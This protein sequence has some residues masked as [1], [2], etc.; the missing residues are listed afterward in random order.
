MRIR[1]LFGILCVAIVAAA[2]QPVLAGPG[3]DAARLFADGKALL[4][5]SDFDGALAAYAAAAKADPKNEEYRQ[6]HALLRRVIKMRQDVQ[7]EKDTAKLESTAAAL[8]AFYYAHDLYRQ[9]LDLDKLVHAKRGTPDAAARL[10]ETQLQLD[11]N[12]DAATLL[13]AVEDPKAT[14]QARLLLGIAL[15]RLGK[16]DDAKSLVKKC[17]KPDELGPGLLFDLARLHALIGDRN[18]ATA[19]LI[20]CFE[21]TPPSRLEAFKAYAKECKD[22]GTLVASAAEFDQI[23]RTQSKVKESACS[24]GAD[25]SKCPSKGSCGSKDAKTAAPETKDAKHAACEVNKDARPATP[26]AEDAPKK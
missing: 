17:P 24:G 11:M 22:L 1:A 21:S 3:D 14:P 25:C 26:E 23:M 16:V 6:Q 13:G 10:A 7:D 9:A 8:R 15:A 12:T 2:C 19:L 20:R 4:A 5:K 18:K